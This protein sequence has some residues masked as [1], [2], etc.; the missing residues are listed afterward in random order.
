[1]VLLYV[2]TVQKHRLKFKIV[3]VSLFKYCNI[4]LYIIN[5]DCLTN[6]HDFERDG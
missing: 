4:F 3:A 2:E 5:C 6:C 1:M